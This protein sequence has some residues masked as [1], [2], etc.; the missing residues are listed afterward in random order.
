MARALS[1]ALRLGKFSFHISHVALCISA[2]LTGVFAQPRLAAYFSFSPPS[3]VSAFIRTYV[4]RARDRPN[5]AR[6]SRTIDEKKSRQEIARDQKC[7]LDCNSRALNSR[8][9]L[10]SRPRNF[11]VSF[12][13]SPNSRIS[14]LSPKFSSDTREI[15]WP[16]MANRIRHIVRLK[17]PQENR[18]N[19]RRGKPEN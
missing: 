5:C 10:S 8:A 19:W 11:W 16:E 6:N 4:R 17:A 13:R 12:G 3:K 9:V 1:A 15:A 18:F 14:R 2:K 7:R